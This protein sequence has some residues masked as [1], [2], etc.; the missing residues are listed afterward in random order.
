MHSDGGSLPQEAQAPP[1]PFST[2]PSPASLRSE[3]AREGPRELAGPPG[4]GGLSPCIRRPWWVARLDHTSEANKQC[5][6]HFELVSLQR[7]FL[8]NYRGLSRIYQKTWAAVPS[9]QQR[10]SLGVGLCVLDRYTC[11]VP[12]WAPIS[13][14]SY[15][16]SLRLRTRKLGEAKSCAQGHRASKRQCQNWNLASSDVRVHAL[17][18]WLSGPNPSDLLPSFLLFL[19]PKDWAKTACLSTS[20]YSFNKLLLLLQNPILILPLL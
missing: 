15:P 1:A 14:H 20:V 8:F 11:S 17:T 3:A 10:A 19:H 4:G 7:L 12:T 9:S 18:A 2:P 13:R 5:G 16:H 6:L